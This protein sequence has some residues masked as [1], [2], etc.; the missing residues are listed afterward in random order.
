MINSVFYETINVS[1]MIHRLYPRDVHLD[2]YYNI[3][4]GLSVLVMHLRAPVFISP[5]RRC[6]RAR[7]PEC[8]R[9]LERQLRFRVFLWEQITGH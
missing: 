4:D 6:F 2:R 7:A 8:A 9:V 1:S 5:A 3:F